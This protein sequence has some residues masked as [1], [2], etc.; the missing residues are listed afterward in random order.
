YVFVRYSEY[1]TGESTWKRM[2]ET[3]IKK[4][5]EAQCLRSTW[6]GIFQGTYSEDEQWEE[7]DITP[8]EGKKRA[9]N[10]T[11]ETTV[12]TSHTP[13]I[14]KTEHDPENKTSTQVS[15]QKSI[16]DQLKKV[17]ESE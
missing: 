16:F 10:K 3:M 7:K 6:Q 17:T 1:N 5:A 4:V 14:P 12:S 15:V 8:Q 2:P 9:E 11:P 13:E